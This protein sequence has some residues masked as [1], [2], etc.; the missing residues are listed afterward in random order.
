MTFQPYVP[1]GGLAGWR[2]LQNTIASQKDAFSA[3]AVVQRDMEY[4]R[5][6]ISDVET[7]EQLVNDFRLLSVAL[8]AFGLSEDIN[9]KFLIRKVLEEGTLDPE[10]LANRLSDTRYRD[11]ARAFGFGDFPVPNT[12]LSDFPDRIA[13]R[14]VDQSFEQAL[15]NTNN[16]MRLALNAQRELV[17]IAEED[18]SNRTKW[19][20][21]MG[22]PPL[23]QVFEG[24]FNLPTSFG[25]LDLDRQLTVFEERTEAAFGTSDISE[26]AQPET[27]ERLLDRFAAVAG[28]TASFGTQVTSPALVLLRGF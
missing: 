9:N 3:S 20:R 27:L 5:E 2:F 7:P 6:K 26:L 24:A 23:R 13:A 8:N 22:T 17:N 19:F 4:F 1:T 25:T 14:Y 21:I 16:T 28:L 11:M 12:A 10:A 15:G 18:S